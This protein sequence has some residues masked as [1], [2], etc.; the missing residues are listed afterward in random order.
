[1]SENR[2]TAAVRRFKISYPDI[3]ESAVRG[4]KSTYEEELKKA[5]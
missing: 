3:E 5:K 4:F 1:M 2:A